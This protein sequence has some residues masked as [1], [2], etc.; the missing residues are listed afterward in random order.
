[1]AADS[2]YIFDA[3]AVIAW[4][5][6]EQGAETVERILQEK[7]GRY[8]LHT[9]NA[10]EVFY[11]I[12]RRAGEARAFQL[13]T[14]LQRLN[15]TLEPSLSSSLWHEAGKLKAAWSR[16][17]LADCVALALAIREKGILVT[18]DHHEF[19]RIAKADLCTVLFIR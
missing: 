1:L 19:D 11:H 10:C 7:D 3:C 16:V 9:I 4:L 8:L 17:S 6:G 12:Y 15:F 14:L 13:E 2:C 5:D 18:S